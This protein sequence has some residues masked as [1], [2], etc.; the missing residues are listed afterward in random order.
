MLVN[1][2][3]QYRVGWEIVWWQYCPRQADSVPVGLDDAVPYG[4]TDVRKHNGHKRR[5]VR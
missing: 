5:S 2:P 3:L 4:I 1:C